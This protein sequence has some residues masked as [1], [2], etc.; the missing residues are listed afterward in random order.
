M[1]DGAG[2]VTGSY[3]PAVGHEQ[4]SLEP[5]LFREVPDPRQ[6]AL[7]EHDARPGQ[8][9]EWLHESGGALIMTSASP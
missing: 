9:I 7:A 4:R 2:D 8:K 3:Q 1:S 5:E 6:G